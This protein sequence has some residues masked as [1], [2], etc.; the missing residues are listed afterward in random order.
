MGKSIPSIAM[1]DYFAEAKQAYSGQAT[2]LEILD[3]A[4]EQLKGQTNGFVTGSV[5]IATYLGSV[6]YTFN[7]VVP[8]LNSY[9][10]PL[11]YVTTN[12]PVTTGYPVTVVETG[13]SAGTECHTSDE[14]VQYLES[15]FNSGT[16]RARI[17]QWVEMAKER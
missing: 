11:F 9:T 12:G 4:A 6:R 14:F 1:P 3:Q 5:Y 2:P 16:T 17:A 10:D 8:R 13:A 7:L 15:I